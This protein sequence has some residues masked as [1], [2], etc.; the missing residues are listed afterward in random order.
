MSGE[1]TSLTL[2]ALYDENFTQ[3]FLILGAIV[4]WVL[5]I[6]I[7]V[8]LKLGESLSLLLRLLHPHKPD[9]RDECEATRAEASLVHIGLLKVRP[10][11]SPFSFSYI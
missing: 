2:K 1:Q 3:V 5:L 10:P 8:A 7:L 9:P 4:I 11:R 6:V